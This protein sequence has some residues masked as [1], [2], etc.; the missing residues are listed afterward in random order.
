MKVCLQVGSNRVRGKRFLQ[1]LGTVGVA[2]TAEKS[3]VIYVRS[4][5]E[6]WSCRFGL[7]ERGKVEIEELVEMN[8]RVID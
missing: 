4:R 3:T 2:H 7:K 8:E 1:L 5:S 6:S